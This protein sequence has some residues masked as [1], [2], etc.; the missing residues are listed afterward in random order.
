M[1]GGQDDV[2]MFGRMLSNRF[3]IMEWGLVMVE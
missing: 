1:V 3:R 2:A